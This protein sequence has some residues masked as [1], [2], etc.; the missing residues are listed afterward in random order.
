MNIKAPIPEEKLIVYLKHKDEKAFELLYDN[1]AGALLGIISRIVKE[2]EEAENV[3]QDTF[4]KIWLNFDRYDSSRGR[5]F[6]WMM[7]IARNSAINFLRIHKNNITEPI[8]NHESWVYNSSTSVEL[9][10]VNYI[11]VR[12]QVSRLDEKLRVIIELIYFMGYTQKEVAD[13]LKLPLGTVKTRTRTALQHIKG[14]I[15]NL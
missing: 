2:E 4:V 5:L 7:A 8:H 3:L 1:Y 11:G 15:G 6:T 10:E 14:F 9:T 13:K 12:E